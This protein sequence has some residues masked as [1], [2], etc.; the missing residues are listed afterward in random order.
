MPTVLLVDD[1]PVQMAARQAVLSNAGFTV[2]IATN[3]QIALTLLRSPSGKIVHTVVTDHMM[4]QVDGAEFVRLLR[5]EG[6]HVPV[7]VVS[8]LPNADAE[9]QDF[10]N[11]YFRLK[12]CSPPDL[13]HLVHELTKAA[14]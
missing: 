4:P 13:I 14:S 6:N 5:A 1:S 8:G 10:D 2:L 7:I 9:Y 3:A 12:P 11:V